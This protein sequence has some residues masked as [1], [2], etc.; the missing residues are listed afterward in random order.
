MISLMHFISATIAGSVS[1]AEEV[2]VKPANVIIKNSMAFLQ[3]LGVPESSIYFINS[4]FLVAVVLIIAFLI[5]WLSSKTLK[6]IFNRFGQH[7]SLILFQDMI[8][9]KLYYLLALIIP[10]GFVRAMIPLVF[11]NQPKLISFNL[12]LFNIYVTIYIIRLLIAF[13]NTMR[14]FLRHKEAYADKPLDSF[15]QVA[16]IIILFL[17]IISIIGTLLGQDPKV[18]LGGLGA[19]S[20]VF[21]LIFKDSILGFV[22]SI[23]VSVNDMVRIG[24]WI[25][26]PS[27]DA[28]GDVIKISLTTVKIK[29]FDNTIIT[30]PTYSLINNTMQN[31]RG[32]KDTGCR[33]VK[34][35][36]RIKQSSIKFLT[37]EELER[38]KEIAFL[39]EYIS[40]KQKEITAYQTKKGI[41]NHHPTHI[42]AITNIALFE[43]YCAQYLYQRNDVSSEM[44]LMVR[45][46]S[47]E[48]TGLPVEIYAFVTTTVWVKYEA[49]VTD[50]FDHLIAFVAFFDLEIFE[51]ITNK[52]PELS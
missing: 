15:A 39:S 29:A 1:N 16:K 22:A 35:A 14:D 47:P 49:I 31:W 10:I 19:L 25:T 26:I 42:P 27:L 33:R 28:D 7:R 32:M 9:N 52:T 13:A 4:T 2:I 48:P 40:R 21:M 43:H 36:I 5:Q 46:L 51:N 3:S 50:I 12:L 37:V 18:L 38:M 8:N 41:D 24:D 23:Q 34:R 30:L 44:T 17:G 11:D 6:K 20:A 45:Q